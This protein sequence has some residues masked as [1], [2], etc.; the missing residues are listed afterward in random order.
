MRAAGPAGG[1][2]PGPRLR[3][4]GRAGIPASP[5]PP[6]CHWPSRSASMPRSSPSSSPCF[7]SVPIDRQRKNNARRDVARLIPAQDASFAAR[8]AASGA[9]CRGT[10]HSRRL[11]TSPAI[12]TTTV[13]TAFLE[14]MHAPRARTA[15]RHRLPRSCAT[16]RRPGGGGRYS[17]RSVW[18]NGRFRECVVRRAARSARGSARTTF[19]E[20]W[21]Q[22]RLEECGSCRTYI[23]AVDLRE[24]GLAVPVV[25]EL[26]SVEFDLWAV[27][28]GLSKRQ[29]NLLGL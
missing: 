24:A 11:A 28:Q 4:A 19:S 13:A 22:V 2:G 18:P 6:S 20:S 5:S 3:A 16:T 23:K 9:N 29:K 7:P 12:V 10:R 8:R 14:T 26:A 17:A 27:E 1:L 15:G 21:P 25:D